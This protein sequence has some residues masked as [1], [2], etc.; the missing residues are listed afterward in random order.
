[1][2]H[3]ISNYKRHSKRRTK[4]RVGLEELQRVISLLLGHPFPDTKDLYVIPEDENQACEDDFQPKVLVK[5]RDAGSR[6][7]T[8]Q[9]RRSNISFLS[10]DIPDEASMPAPSREGRRTGGSVLRDQTA[11]KKGL[12]GGK[13]RE[14]DQVEVEDSRPTFRH[15]GSSFLVVPQEGKLTK[16]GKDTVL[17]TKL[18]PTVRNSREKK[19]QFVDDRPYRG[20]SD[21]PTPTIERNRSNAAEVLAEYGVNL[22][23]DSINP[24]QLKR[25][26]RSPKLQALKG[27]PDMPKVAPISL[28]DIMSKAK[29]KKQALAPLPATRSKP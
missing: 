5:G 26:Y 10:S 22:S 2:Q 7:E 4:R 6:T 13:A 20:S 15:F 18:K 23:Q 12:E 14:M 27:A 11:E 21:S 24:A 25:S 29:A 8:A 1:M 19:S 3:L 17:R 28:A 9:S 16:S